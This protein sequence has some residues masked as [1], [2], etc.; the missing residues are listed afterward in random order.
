MYC[1][2]NY[3]TAGEWFSQRV[4][5]SNSA[6]GFVSNKIWRL[7]DYRV[8]WTVDQIR[9]H[10]KKPVVMNDWLWGGNNEQRGFRS[11]SELFD[12]ARFNDTGVFGLKLSSSTSQHCFGRACDCKVSGLPADEIREDIRKNP[13]AD[14]YKHITCVEEGVSWLHFDVRSWD[15]AKYGILFF[16]P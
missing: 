11:I 10:F 8:T 4:I 16:H 2:P 1:I 13:Y 9:K 7:V 6:V 3:F 5:Q 12:S 15:K 14:R